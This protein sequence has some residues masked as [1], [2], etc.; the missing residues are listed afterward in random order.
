MLHILTDGDNLLDQLSTPGTWLHVHCAGGAGRTTTALVMLA[1]LAMGDQ[2]A[3]HSAT[4]LLHRAVR[5]QYV[6]GGSWLLA[7]GPGAQLRAARDAMQGK[8]EA[9]EGAHARRRWSPHAAL[10]ALARSM[11]R[12]DASGRLH[13]AP[14]RHESYAARDAFLHLFAAFV[15]QRA[16]READNET[17]SAWLSN[18]LTTLSRE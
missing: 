9:A 7:R 3:G 5:V 11:Q 15:V 2:A 16:G 12:T 6:L 10:W 4:R 18:H 14:T 17:W 8:G 1:L 13:P